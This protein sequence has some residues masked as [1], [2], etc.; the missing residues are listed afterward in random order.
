MKI[1]RPFTVIDAGLTSNI[2]DDAAPAY[3]ATTV[4]VA[5]QQVLYDT[6]I[7]EALSGKSGTVT[8]AGVSN[9]SPFAINW[10]AHGLA[11][12]TAVIFSGTTPTGV[13]AGTV[14]L[15]ASANLLADSFQITT[16]A[17]A[18]VTNPGSTANTGS[19]PITA[20]AGPYN[21]QPDSNPT[22]WL[23]TGAENRWKM[24]D[25]RVQ[26]QTVGADGTI[27]VSIAITEVIDTVALLNISGATTASC[28]FTTVD[29]VVYNVTAQTRA[30]EGV[31]DM[32]AYF[33]EPIA[34]VTDITF[35][36]IPPYASGTLTLTLTNELGSPVYC[37]EM[38]LGHALNIG[39]TEVGAKVGVQDYSIKS[40]DN[41]GNYTI[42]QRAYSKRAS[43]TVTLES[44]LVDQTQNLLALYRAT[45]ILYIGTEL[46]G[47]TLVYGF[48]KTFEIDIGYS[49]G[50]STC[51]LEVEGLT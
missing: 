46:Y 4:Y 29:G 13:T 24:F 31:D 22:A 2:P 23:D 20:T 27:E 3:D 34:Y 48:Y 45:P 6:H 15:I 5:G 28:V 12:G 33:F 25:A 51:S 49:D 1:I 14:Y 26:A 10:T 8:F 7:Y 30:V 18:S 42:V 40:Q 47:A 50:T 35:A 9:G 32:Y 19:A 21:Q 43:F 16:Q 17:G 41:F 11:A 39:D 38:I 44:K 36:D 37:G